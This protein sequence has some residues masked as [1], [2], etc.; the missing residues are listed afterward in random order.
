MGLRCLG[1]G[2]EGVTELL[3]MGLVLFEASVLPWVSLGR[4]Q[5]CT[6]YLNV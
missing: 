3:I 6:A 1:P 5:G 4:L 2:A